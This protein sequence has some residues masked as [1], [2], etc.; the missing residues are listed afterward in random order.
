MTNILI[1]YISPVK[2]MINYSDKTKFSVVGS[3]DVI[4]GMQ[5]NE[6]GIKYV[7]K[8]LYDQGQQLDRMICLCSEDVMNK[9]ETVIIDGETYEL[10]TINYLEKIITEKAKEEIGYDK[11]AVQ[12]VKL[13]IKKKEFE[14]KISEIMSKVNAEDNVYIDTTGGFRD[15][16]IYIQLIMNILKYRN[17]NIKKMV[18][19]ELVSKEIRDMSD[20]NS[21]YS[22][23]DGV[24]QFATSGKADILKREFRSQ[25]CSQMRAVIN[26]MGRFAEALQ[27][28][29][30]S[31]LDGILD[32][33]NDAIE[34][35][36]TVN[37]DDGIV[38]V[39]RNVLPAIENK[40]VRA[41]DNYCTIIK[42]CLD[43]G[44]I[45]QALTLYIEK[46]PDYLLRNRIITYKNNNYTDDDF[47]GTMNG[48]NKSAAIFYEKF[49]SLDSS[50]EDPYL[51]KVKN[52]L[53]RYQDNN[54]KFF[55]DLRI[56]ELIRT[57]DK[58]RSDW[59]G[60]ENNKNIT[61]KNF[62]EF[63]SKRF[64]RL[65][66][67]ANKSTEYKIV[68]LAYIN[69]YTAFDS[70]LKEI[71]ENKPCATQ[72]SKLKKY[73]SDNE[74]KILDEL[75]EIEA[76]EKLETL[77]KKFRTI[78]RLTQKTIDSSDFTAG[79]PVEDIKRIMLDYIYAKAT[80]NQINHASEEENL[81]EDQKKKL[82][83]YFCDDG[84]SRV[85]EITRNLRRAVEF[86]ED[87]R[88]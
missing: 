45:Q 70:L 29:D 14:S 5:T 37:S 26:N 32:D 17:V 43:N 84:E 27:L 33:L 2:S 74:K 39:F 50:C 87:L 88:K 57:I 13:E 86:I 80:R 12:F 62:R 55:Y 78:E 21:Y 61:N 11:P 69:S 38:S 30:T 16:V 79:I 81:T 40:F 4:Y 53:K 60:I 59:R 73:L 6:A 9:K 41:N 20:I 52:C 71:I 24:N 65:Y 7:M 34:N 68:K 8:Q 51:T 82:V 48:K 35:M 3:D 66:E 75:F 23:L 42:W 63:I 56:D 15:A 18:Y 67:T 77:E 19:T 49:M 36:K 1:S 64:D 44:L 76:P 72:N 83:G 25:K 31:E 28:C 47:K 46:I 85:E 22:I 58:L 10:T 54:E